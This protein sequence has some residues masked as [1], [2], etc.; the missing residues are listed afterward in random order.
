MGGGHPS[1]APTLRRRCGA[2]RPMR[3]R[4]YGLV[5]ASRP[6]SLRWAVCLRVAGVLTAEQAEIAEMQALLRT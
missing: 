6:A 1:I 5:R 3:A 2:C 4:D